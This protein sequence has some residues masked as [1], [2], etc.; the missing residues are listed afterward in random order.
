MKIVI[1]G[2]AYP[3][4]GGIATYNERMALEF[5]N[6]GHEVSIYTFTLQY[7]GILFPGKTQFA[8]KKEKPSIKIKRCINSINPL[9]WLIV[10]NQLKNQKPDILI[11]RY[12]IPFMGPAFG[13]I[14]RRIKKNGVTRILALVDNMIPHES[15]I[16][17]TQFT[18]Y[19]IKPID[20]YIAMSE[21]VMNDIRSFDQINPITLTPHPL[22]DN[23]GTKISRKE[24]L[25]NLGLNS[26][27]R[28]MLYFGFI[29]KYKGL[30]L[31]L[32][33][34]GHE[35][36]KQKN[37]K[38][39]I[40]GEYYV[41]KEHYQKIIRDLTIGDQIIQYDKF[42]RDDEVRN[43]FCASDLVVQPYRSATQSGVT[44]IAYHFDKPMIVTNV[45]GLPELCP[46]EKVGFVTKPEPK[47][48]G[49]AIIRFFEEPEKQKFE[50]NIKIEKEKYSW[51]ILTSNI[52]KLAQQ[53]NKGS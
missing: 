50:E 13:A 3:Y 23:F 29:R 5:Q 37:I 48:I 16:G 51:T 11:V 6:E 7:P 2:P 41:N 35:Y 42:I 22:F 25:L 9:N 44:Q 33:A 52:I 34:F 43:L 14:L 27:Y 4:R 21:N 53:I 46:H 26:N 30:D 19:F 12:W 47:S 28:Y 18:K 38:L 36:F 15:R 45:G 39:I 49:E 31:L 40:A 24:A 32:K 8:D 1:V 20:G 10:G 17:D